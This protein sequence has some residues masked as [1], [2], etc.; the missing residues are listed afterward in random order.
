VPRLLAATTLNNAC[1]DPGATM[2]ARLPMIATVARAASSCRRGLPSVSLRRSFAWR[3]FPRSVRRW[4]SPPV[5]ASMSISLSSHRQ[6]LAR[7]CRRV[8]IGIVPIS[9]SS[10][11]TPALSAAQAVGSHHLRFMQPRALG[12]KVSDE[13]AVPL[14]R[15]HHRTV[16]RSGNEVAWWK[17]VG[18]DPVKIARK[19]WKQERGD[20]GGRD[21]MTLCPTLDKVSSESKTR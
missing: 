5:V 21:S 19:L 2:A 14:C 17:Q 4:A 9:G 10:L 16:H 12:R 20:Q 7:S 1:C 18:I 8:V 15:E 11:R 3:A 13:Y 6:E